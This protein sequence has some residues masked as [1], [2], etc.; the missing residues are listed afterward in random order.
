MSKQ[1]ERR[2]VR[3]LELRA[4]NDDLPDGVVGRL[5]GYASVFER[6]SAEFS[7]WEKPWVERVAK[8]AFTRTLSEKRDQVALHS[9][10][11]G[12]PLAKRGKGL[13]LSEDAHG[14]AVEIDLPDTNDGRDL[15]AQVKRGLIDAMSFGFRVI[16]ESI[17]KGEARD[18]RTLDE[19]ELHEVSAVLFP[20]YPDTSLAVRSLKAAQ[21]ESTDAAAKREAD[22]QQKLSDAD[23][24]AGL[25]GS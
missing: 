17:E 20:A 3:E 7:G 4:D 15:L 21:E 8:G 18:V 24:G 19:V 1:I 25:F 13:E 6:D 14:L 5:R 23:F 12:R 9:H 16:K 10:D 11:D 22:E 2:A